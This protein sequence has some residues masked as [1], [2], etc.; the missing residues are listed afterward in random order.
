ML[1]AEILDKPL[2]GTPQ[3]LPLLLSR[4]PLKNMMARNMQVFYRTYSTP[5]Y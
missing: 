1:M 3:A 2:Q 4:L 5:H